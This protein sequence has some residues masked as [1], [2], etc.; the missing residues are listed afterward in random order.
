MATNWECALGVMSLLKRKR[1]T[2]LKMFVFGLGI[3]SCIA[4]APGLY[5]RD[6]YFIFLLPA[7][8]LLC[9]IGMDTIADF[10]KMRFKR[11][12]NLKM[13]GIFAGI[14]FSLILIE[15]V[16]FL[17]VPNSLFKIG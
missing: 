13:M 14:S 6:H 10:V 12:V 7:I 11:F 5:F 16:H 9:G 2:T 4:T 3:F 17:R 1:N 15:R 8:A